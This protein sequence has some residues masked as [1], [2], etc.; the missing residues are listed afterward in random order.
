MSTHEQTSVDLARLAQ[1]LDAYGAAP[2]QWPEAERAGA[3][4]LLERDAQA[5]ALQQAAL[6]LDALLDAAPAFEVAP[7]LRA[8]VLEIPIKHAHGSVRKPSWF[9]L[10]SMALF[11]LVPCF[12]GFL[13][14][15][16]YLDAPS[17]SDD[18]T[19]DE[20]AAVMSP[21]DVLDEDDVL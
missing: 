21:A 10:R 7:A 5:R 8:R 9:G 4:R 15:A 11:A 20:V 6:Q 19:W 13:S 1:L 16:L 18:D 14:G 2:A 12:I 3:L 17:D